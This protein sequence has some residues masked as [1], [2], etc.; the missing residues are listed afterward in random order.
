[1][2]RNILYYN[3]DN[4]L[5]CN[6]RDIQTQSFT[7]FNNSTIDL[8]S[9]K[10]MISIDIS[11]TVTESFYDAID[12]STE[13]FTDSPF[14]ITI[15]INDSIQTFTI[16]QYTPICIHITRYLDIQSPAKIT[17]SSNYSDLQNIDIHVISERV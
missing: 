10:Y 7:S 12:N 9:G 17:I 6:A 1:M 4:T 5:R 16:G 8:Q 3:E 2:S 13:T 11:A 14:F 15:K